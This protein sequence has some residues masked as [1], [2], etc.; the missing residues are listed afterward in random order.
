MRRVGKSTIIKTI[1]EYLINTGVQEKN[2][3]DNCGNITT[4]K[5]ISDYFKN[6]K[7]TATIDKVIN[8]LKYLETAFLITK[9][10]RYDIKGL[11][12]LE[13]YEKYYAG[14]IGLRHGLIGYKDNDVRGLIE[15][16]VYLELLQRGY[17]VQVGKFDDLEIDFIA[18][19]QNEKMYIQIAYSL[20]APETIEREFSVLE[21]INDNYPKYVLSMD[22]FQLFNRNGIQS[23]YLLDYLLKKDS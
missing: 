7:I 8:Y 23:M 9:A 10:H 22:E 4:A 18:E 20:S 11:R 14:D 6:Q 16:I 3:F 12:Q 19:K 1:I 2:I 13:I 21:K 17:H 5:R 15:N